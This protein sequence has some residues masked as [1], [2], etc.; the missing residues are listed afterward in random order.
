MLLLSLRGIV[1]SSRMLDLLRKLNF[2]QVV[3]IFFIVGFVAH[4][5]DAIAAILATIFPTLC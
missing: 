2:F 1:E 4:F 3:A 5:Y